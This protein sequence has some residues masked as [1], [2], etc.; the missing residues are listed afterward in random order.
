MYLRNHEDVISRVLTKYTTRIC[1][2][3]NSNQVDDNNITSRKNNQVAACMYVRITLLGPG[4]LAELTICHSPKQAI[5][6]L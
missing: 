2:F 1:H 4:I 3:K 6:L 5:V